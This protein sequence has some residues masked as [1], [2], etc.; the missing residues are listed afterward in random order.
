MKK[1]LLAVIAGTMLLSNIAFA[2]TTTAD[3]N[4]TKTKSVSVV[5]QDNAIHVDTTDPE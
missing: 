3:A 1:V 4:G 2:S 5:Y